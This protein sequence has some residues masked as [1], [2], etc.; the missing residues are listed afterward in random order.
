LINLNGK[1]S[2]RQKSLRRKPKK[3]HW[4]SKKNIKNQNVESIFKFDQNIKS[5]INRSWSECRKCQ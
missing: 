1:G 2:E 3:E 4:K 5:D